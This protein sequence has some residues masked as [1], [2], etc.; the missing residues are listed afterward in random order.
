MEALNEFADFLM[1]TVTVSDASHQTSKEYNGVFSFLL[2]Q[3]EAENVSAPLVTQSHAIIDI[4]LDAVIACRKDDFVTADRL[5]AE[6]DELLTLLPPHIPMPKLFKLSAW[7]NYFYKTGEWDR[8]VA[9]LKEG[10]FISAELER[11]GYPALIFRRI[12]QLQNIARIYQKKG[13]FESANNL[14]KNS[15]IFL[16]SGRAN[17]LIIEDWDYKLI[18]QVRLLQ[19]NTLDAVFNQLAQLNSLL[20]AHQEYNDEYFCRHF[21]STFLEDMPADLYN[22]VIIYNWMFIKNSYFNDGVEAYFKNLTAFFED[23]EIS[24]TY[25]HLKANLL[26]QVVW[27]VANCKGEAESLAVR[28]I[29][30]YAAMHLKDFTGKPFKIVPERS[31]LV[32]H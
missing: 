14:L 7:G 19:E 17:G 25:D 21:F 22:R 23:T 18:R 28:K 4:Y 27:C 3:Q 11:K 6:A 12:E 32:K 2:R 10:L 5:L 8:A 31:V 29:R 24:S 1:N 16:Y 13:D 30:D 20:I 26:T 15:I 9:L